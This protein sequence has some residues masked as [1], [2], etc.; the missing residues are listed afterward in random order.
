[1]D[2]IPHNHYVIKKSRAS[3]RSSELHYL[4]TN[5]LTQIIM[6]ELNYN[7]LRCKGTQYFEFCI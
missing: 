6:Y 7:Y 2:N 3:R 4:L 1:M 5:L